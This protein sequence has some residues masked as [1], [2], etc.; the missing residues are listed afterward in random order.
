MIKEKY[1]T[2]KKGM[3]IVNKYLAKI[4][5]RLEEKIAECEYKKYQREFEE[6]LNDLKGLE[7]NVRK[8]ISSY[9]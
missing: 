3:E 4:R 7:Y 1:P 5:S 2:P 9:S 6:I 8:I